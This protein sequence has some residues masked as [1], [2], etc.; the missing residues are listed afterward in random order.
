M[1]ASKIAENSMPG[2]IAQLTDIPKSEPSNLVKKTKNSLTEET[3]FFWL[4]HLVKT[5]EF[6][7]LLQKQGEKIF[8]S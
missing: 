7:I 5:L 2:R 4:P 8:F 6:Y 1:G 3:C